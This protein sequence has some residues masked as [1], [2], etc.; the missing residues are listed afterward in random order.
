MTPFSILMKCK[1]QKRTRKF[2]SE[3]SFFLHYIFNEMQSMG[4]CYWNLIKSNW[5]ICNVCWVSIWRYE[6]TCY[7]SIRD[8]FSLS[9][10][11]LCNRLSFRFFAPLQFT[12]SVHKTENVMNFLIKCILNWTLRF[13]Y[14][15][16]K[17][18]KL[19]NAKRKRLGKEFVKRKEKRWERWIKKSPCRCIKYAGVT[20]NFPDT[21]NQNVNELQCIDSFW[22]IK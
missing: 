15:Y 13:M 17:W 9:L 4:F 8:F 16:Q 10:S 19:R 2:Q 1:M 5:K 20:Y 7:E 12:Q 3:V 14:T 6:K 21:V 11:R 22:S 18:N